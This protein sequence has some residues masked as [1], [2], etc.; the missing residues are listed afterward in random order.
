MYSYDEYEQIDEDTIRRQVQAG[1][2][3]CRKLISTA[4]AWRAVGLT[5]IFL[6]LEDDLVA[7]LSVERLESYLN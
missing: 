7:C 4:D 3:S 5:P 6:L 1:S 2:E